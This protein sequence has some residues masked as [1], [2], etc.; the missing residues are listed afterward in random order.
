M[1]ERVAA[2]PFLCRRGRLMVVLVTTRGGG[3]WVLPKGRLE[4]DLSRRQVAE[5]EAFEEGGILGRAHGRPASA[6]VTL[7]RRTLSLAVYPLEVRRLLRA[8]PEARDRRRRTVAVDALEACGLEPGW[9]SC[10]RRL[11]RLRG[12]SC[13]RR[14]AMRTLPA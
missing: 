12:I 1:I 8:W 13:P 3:R 4:D 11:A 2:C 6:T 9:I 5:L 14:P 10:I 7:G